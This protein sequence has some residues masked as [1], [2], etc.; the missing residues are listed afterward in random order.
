[1]GVLNAPAPAPMAMAMAMA[2]WSCCFAAGWHQRKI[3]GMDAFLSSGQI[4][5]VDEFLM[6]LVFVCL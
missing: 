3:A 4:W 1:M 2:A 6:T 5:P